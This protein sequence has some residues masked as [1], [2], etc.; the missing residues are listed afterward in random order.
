MMLAPA[1]ADDPA[2]EIEQLMKAGEAAY[3]KADYGAARVSYEKAWQLAQQTPNK[4]PVRYD[5]LK[6]LTAVSAALGQ[7]TEADNYLQLAINWR[8]TII[9][10]DD[11]KIADDLL[12]SVAV[13]RGM[14]DLDRAQAILE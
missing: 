13:C 14:K 2:A 9:S 12:V 5:I 8:E 7:F 4:N 10:R 11:P 3:V 6:H 1:F